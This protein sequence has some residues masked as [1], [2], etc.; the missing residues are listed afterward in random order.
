MKTAELSQAFINAYNQRDADGLR[1]LIADE[2]EYIRPGGILRE[3]IDH[4][5]AAYEK[6]WRTAD[7]RVAV[8]RL[9]STNTQVAAEIAIVNQSG[10]SL[11]EGGVF[12]DWND[13]KLVRYRAYFD[14]L[15]EQLRTTK[16][17][18]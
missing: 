12:H 13:G 7:V 10:D 3:S 8:R 11:F 2:I 5:V 16:K 9:V 6:E 18:G 17:G 1:A 4:V 14:P 15:P